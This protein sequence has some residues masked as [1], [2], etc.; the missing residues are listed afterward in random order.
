M[1]LDNKQLYNLLEEM[2]IPYLYHA[3]SLKTFKTYVENSGIMSRGFV[4][5]MGLEQSP[6]SSDEVDKAIGV[7]DDIFL[8]T[9]DLHGYFPRQNVYG[10]IQM[11]FRNELVLDEK[12]EFYVTKDNPIYWETSTKQEDRYF[13]SVEELKANWDKYQRQRKMFTIKNIDEPI[14]FNYLQDIIIDDPRVQFTEGEMT[15]IV[16]NEA[17][18]IIDEL[19][20][21][22]PELRN[23]LKVRTCS[24]CFCRQN[25][26]EQVTVSDLK[27]LF[28]N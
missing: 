17:K 13:V 10:P 4:E 24:G 8:D 20:E 1:R 9:V 7:W 28:L 14:I 25:Y 15:T 18:K 22:Y 2:K 6:Q 26:L 21:N 16:F 23:K 11:R 27:R 5:R 3:N 19:V 12:F